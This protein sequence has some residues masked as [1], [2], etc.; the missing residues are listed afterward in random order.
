MDKIFKYV[1]QRKAKFIAIL[2]G[3]EVAAGTVTVRNVAHEDEGNDAESAK[4][5]SF[6]TNELLS[7]LARASA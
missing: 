2:G 4:R 3:D 6:I 1:D 7:R 5:Q